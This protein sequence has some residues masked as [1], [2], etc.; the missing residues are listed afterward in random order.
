VQ[1]FESANAQVNTLSFLLPA[2][3]REHSNGCY[4]LGA[5]YI[6]KNTV[7]C[8]FDVIFGFLWTC[9]MYWPIGFGQDSWSTMVYY[10]VIILLMTSE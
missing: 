3:M 2:V 10:Y 4:S 7:D 5:Y 8:F 6:S 9:A 1:F